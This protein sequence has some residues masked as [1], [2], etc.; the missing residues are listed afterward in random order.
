MNSY[1]RGLLV[2]ILLLRAVV[3]FL[4]TA[5]KEVSGMHF[6][7]NTAKHDSWEHCADHIRATD[8]WTPQ[9]YKQ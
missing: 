5:M 4:L 8:L 2:G 1:L 3:G 9:R 6:A 7:P